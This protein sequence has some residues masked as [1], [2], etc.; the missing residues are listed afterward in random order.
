MGI[1]TDDGIVHSSTSRR[2]ESKLTNSLVKASTCITVPLAFGIGAL[3]GSTLGTF[4]IYCA[5]EDIVKESF[6]LENNYPNNPR[7][8]YAV[9]VAYLTGR[10]AG[11][12][13]ILGG[14]LYLIASNQI[15]SDFMN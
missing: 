6:K 12:A 11:Q 1:N 7:L 15:K 2:K 14:L 13:S 10:T 5:G 3:V 8:G 9:E 4:S